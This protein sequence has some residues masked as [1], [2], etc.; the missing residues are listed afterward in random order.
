MTE[1]LGLL[2]TDDALEAIAR[3]VAT[4]LAEET[5]ARPEPVAFTIATLAT[6][7]DVTEKTI[8]GAIHR[9]ELPA[10]R[11]GTRYLIASD[12]A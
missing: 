11:R 9:G 5:P 3:R 6:E 8:R 12:A 7:L 4:L 10:V 1:A 2:L